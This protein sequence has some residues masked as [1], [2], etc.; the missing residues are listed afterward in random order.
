MDS[1]VIELEIS[2]HSLVYLCRQASIPKEK[3]KGVETR[4]D[5]S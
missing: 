5:R 4:Q 2:D 3:P 1:D